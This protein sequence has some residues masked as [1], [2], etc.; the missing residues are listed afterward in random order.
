MVSFFD[1][2]NETKPNVTREIEG[3]NEPQTPNECAKS[4]MKG[5]V[6]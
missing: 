1:I 6:G 5:N 3:A 4:L 2:Q